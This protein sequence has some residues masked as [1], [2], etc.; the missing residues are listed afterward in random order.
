LADTDASH[1]KAPKNTKESLTQ[2][3]SAEQQEKERRQL[4]IVLHNIELTSG[5]KAT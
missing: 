3:A 2:L 1:D 4:N 5:E